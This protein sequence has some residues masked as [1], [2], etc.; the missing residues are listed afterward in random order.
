MPADSAPTIYDLKD[1]ERFQGPIQHLCTLMLSEALLSKA[2]AVRIQ[3][4]DDDRGAIAYD[5]GDR[6]E[7]V[8]QV[9][10]GVYGPLIDRLKEMAELTEVGV[11]YGQ[12]RVR[13]EDIQRV[14]DVRLDPDTGSALMITG[15]PCSAA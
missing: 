1:K 2:Q 10:G 4:G 11:Q 8:M 12:I 3:M 7:T 5:R 13:Y 15:F 9:P 6:W 14:L